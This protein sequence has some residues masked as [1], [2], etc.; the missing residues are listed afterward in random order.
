MHHRSTMGMIADVARSFIGLPPLT[1]AEYS[2]ASLDLLDPATPDVT[3]FDSS[4]DGGPVASFDH[5]MDDLSSD[6]WSDD[7]FDSMFDSMD[8]CCALGDSFY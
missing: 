4:F 7:G 3:S 2:D 1:A 8:D 5:G 6:A